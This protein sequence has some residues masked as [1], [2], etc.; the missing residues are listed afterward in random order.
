MVGDSLTQDIEGARRVGMTGVL[1]RRSDDGDA[2]RASADV[3]VIKSLLEL[4]LRCLLRS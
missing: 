3:P 4:T 1:V 2:S